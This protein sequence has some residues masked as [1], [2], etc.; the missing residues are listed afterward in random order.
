LFSIL[1]TQ[2]L[3][4]WDKYNEW[5]IALTIEKIIKIIEVKSRERIAL[6]QAARDLL[7]I[8]KGQ[9]IAFMKDSQPGLRVVKV[10]LD[11]GEKA[12]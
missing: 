12:E 8:E 1:Q 5:G 3:K 9:Y 4:R 11:L 6:P 7:N 10:K 2:N